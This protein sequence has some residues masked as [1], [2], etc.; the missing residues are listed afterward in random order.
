MTPKKTHQIFAPE[1]P[2]NKKRPKSDGNVRVEESPNIDA[3]KKLGNGLR[4]LV[5]PNKNQAS[6][7]IKRKKSFYDG[8][9]HLI[10]EHS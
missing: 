1:T 10:L 5:T 4:S 6:D 7:M 9:L 3:A 2:K 8:T